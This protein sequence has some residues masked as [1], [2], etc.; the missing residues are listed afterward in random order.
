[1]RDIWDSLLTKV[2][3]FLSRFKVMREHNIPFMPRFHRIMTET[4]LKQAYIYAIEFRGNLYVQDIK[5]VE[6]DEQKS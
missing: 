3:V 1:M 5:L 6:M 4:D 2:V